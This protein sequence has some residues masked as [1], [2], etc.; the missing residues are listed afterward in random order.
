MRIHAVSH[1]ATDDIYREKPCWSSHP[2]AGGSGPVLTEIGPIL[3]RLVNPLL[4]VNSLSVMES[5]WGNVHGPTPTAGEN[6]TGWAEATSQHSLQWF[7]WLCC[8]LPPTWLH[9]PALACPRPWAS[10]SWV[11]SSVPSPL[12][13]PLLSFWPGSLTSNCLSSPPGSQGCAPF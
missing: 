11:S 2:L 6:S 4:G 9:P 12:A 10:L 8:Y 5:S 7:L 3:P 1:I 13:I